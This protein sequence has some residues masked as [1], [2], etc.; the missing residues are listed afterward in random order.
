MAKAYSSQSHYLKIAFDE[1]FDFQEQ[2]KKLKRY[3]EDCVV[4]LREL[5]ESG[6]E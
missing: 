4:L 6:L 3:H 1:D 5:E 2:V